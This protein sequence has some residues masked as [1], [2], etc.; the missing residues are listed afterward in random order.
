MAMHLC[1]NAIQ[2]KNVTNTGDKWF[3]FLWQDNFSLAKLSL[4]DISRMLEITEKIFYFDVGFG[5]CKLGAVVVQQHCTD[6]EC[7]TCFPNPHS[8]TA[9]TPAPKNSQ[10]RQINANILEPLFWGTSPS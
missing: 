10:S 7:V 4:P 1:V 3:H 5:S 8:Q 2:L 9:S 6:Q